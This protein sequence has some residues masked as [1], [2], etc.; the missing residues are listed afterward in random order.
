MDHDREN[1]NRPQDTDASNALRSL[2][3]IWALVA[4][5]AYGGYLAASYFFGG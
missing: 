3:L 4:V 2:A 1:P 5:L